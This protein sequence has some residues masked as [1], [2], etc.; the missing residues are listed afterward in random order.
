MKNI[1][2][3]ISIS[4]IIIIIVFII[5]TFVERNSYITIN[6]YAS[7]DETIEVFNNKISKIKNNEC[8]LSLEYMINRIKDNKM[9]GNIKIKDYYESFY[10]D[11]MT[12]IDYYNYVSSSCNINNSKIYNEALSSLLYPETIKNRYESSYVFKIKD[13]FND[14]NRI[15]EM[16]TYTTIIHELNVVDMFL[17][18]LL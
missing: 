15:D 5:L 1:I 17:E 9:E 16:G 10:K 8:K 12:F 14:N 2:F 3:G 6:S 7:F 13:I 4:F 11:D 18:E